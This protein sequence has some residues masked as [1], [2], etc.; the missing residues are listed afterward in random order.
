[1]RYQAVLG[2]QKAWYRV[3]PAAMGRNN[4]EEVLEGSLVT[5]GRGQVKCQP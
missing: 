3:T 2:N 4:D 5:S 1:M